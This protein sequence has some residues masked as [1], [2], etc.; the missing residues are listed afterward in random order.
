MNKLPC[1][2][3]E[4]EC[5]SHTIKGFFLQDDRTH[6]EIVFFTAAGA[7]VIGSLM[8]CLMGSGEEQPWNRIESDKKD[9]LT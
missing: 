6:W 5:I 7:Y 4:H 8:F 3:S 1:I 2:S 9:S